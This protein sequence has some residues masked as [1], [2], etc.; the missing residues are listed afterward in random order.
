MSLQP[1]SVSEV[2]TETA[3]VAR[4]AFRKGNPYLRFR[5]EFGSLFTDQDF[6][7]LYPS[8]GQPALSPGQLALVT[9]VQF[10]ENLTDRQMA[11]Q[12]RARIDLKYLLNL[13]LTDTGFDFSVLSELAQCQGR[14]R[15]A[16]W[17]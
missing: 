14:C 12:V 8:R 2:P 3:R 13:E 10:T 15:L 4:A 6:V 9:L 1:K 7:Q 17:P 16:Q 5:D 11:D